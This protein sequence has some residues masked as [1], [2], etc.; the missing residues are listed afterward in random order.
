MSS[1]RNFGILAFALAVVVGVSACQKKQETTTS[2]ADTTM[3]AESPYPVEETPPTAETTTPP[4]ENPPATSGK[5]YTPPR[6]TKP[7]SG[8][9]T[10]AATTTVRIP[11]GT[12]MDLVMV[13]DASTKTSNIGDP[14]EAKLAAP[15]VI[16][17]KVVAEE[18]ATVSGKIVDL[19]RASHAKDQ[20][21]R[22][23]LKYDFTTLETVAGSKSLNATVTSSEGKELEAKSTSTR[24]KLLIGGGTVA[25]AVI[26][27]VAGGST[28]STIIGAVG[29]AVVG[30]GVV[31]ASKGHELAI[32]SGAK[33]VLKTEDPITVVMAR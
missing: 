28:K 33:V 30:A 12:T 22:A 4:A 7:K 13:T 17:G 9:A 8:G 27:K 20:E 23:Y 24:D 14:I 5:P 18:G 21:G 25:G 32:P 19:K 29:G 6:S 31:A 10:T 2:T 3:S 15:L 26:G 1:L 16:G 11:A